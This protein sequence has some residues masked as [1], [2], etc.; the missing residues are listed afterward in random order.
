V[1]TRVYEVL[2]AKIRECGVL[3]NRC[4][5]YSF[6]FFCFLL[7]FYDAFLS[8][9][10]AF[11]FISFLLWQCLHAGQALQALLPLLNNKTVLKK[12]KTERNIQYLK[13]AHIL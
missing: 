7:L 4:F 11:F 6:G 9:I 1:R 12:Y 13:G 8:P 2:V 5:H 10:F 3:A